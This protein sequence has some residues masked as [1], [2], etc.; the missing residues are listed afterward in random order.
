MPAISSSREV[1]PRF[2]L[3]DAE[4]VSGAPHLRISESNVAPGVRVSGTSS[5]ASAKIELSNP[6]FAFSFG[7]THERQI[8]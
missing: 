7:D 3:A 4:T 5:R 6:G 8:V 2:A 1:S